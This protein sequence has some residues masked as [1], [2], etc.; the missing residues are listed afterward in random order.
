MAARPSVQDPGDRVQGD[1][2]RAP[3]ENYANNSS[4]PG[5]AAVARRA[6]YGRR[7]LLWDVSSLERVRKCGRVSVLPG[8]AVAVRLR[9]GVAGFAGLAT[10]GSV[11]SDPVCNAK[12]MA[13]RAVEVGA[14][15]ATAQARGMHVVFATFTMRHHK[16]QALVGLWTALASG[17]AKVTSGAEWVKD[18]GRWQIRGWLRVVEVTHGANGWH[19]HVHVLLF[20][21][22]KPSEDAVQAL[23]GRM[24]ARWSRSLE[25]QGL[26]A[27]LMI[28]QDAHLVTG[29]ADKHLAE[30]FTKATDA[31]RIG[32]EVTQTQS[33]AARGRHS[34]RTPWGL[35]DDVQNLGLVDSLALWHEWEQGSKGRKQLTWSVGFRKE[36]GLLAEETDEDIA[37]QEHGSADDDL[38]LIEAEGWR[39]LTL[40]PVD[41]ADL[42]TVTQGQGLAGLRRFLDVRGIPYRL[43]EDA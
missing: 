38:V 21:E 20:L 6:R 3:L 15:V 35:L 37:G 25:R 28:G 41:L 40:V 31:R 10:C 43:M 2:Q 22:G 32:L 42:L 18:K 27:P 33:K 7:G 11:W 26:R 30:Y 24:F 34:T 12:V 8:G 5:P 23:H 36:L 29:A 13:R 16:G 9:G 19:V 14:A 39:H 4:R 17:W 1:A